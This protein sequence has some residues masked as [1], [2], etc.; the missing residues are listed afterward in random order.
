[1]LSVQYSS[2][3]C[4]LK[5][6]TLVP[7]LPSLK[8][9]LADLPPRWRG[10]L[11]LALA[12][13]LLLGAALGLSVDEAHYALYAAHPALSYFDHPPLVVGGRGS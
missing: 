5:A 6:L 13:H 9:W 1:L 3:P 4:H 2:P 10:G 12:L 7:N 11:L 8:A